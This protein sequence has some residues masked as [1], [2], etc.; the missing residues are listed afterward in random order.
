MV[1]PLKLSL[2]SIPPNVTGEVFTLTTGFC[3]SSFASFLAHEFRSSDTMQIEKKIEIFRIW[4]IVNCKLCIISV[5]P[6]II[7][8]YQQLFLHSLQ[9]YILS[10]S[11]NIFQQIFRAEERRVGKECRSR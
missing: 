7:G 6:I 1:L 10:F 11:R 8:V 3:S 4:I 5:V 2:L 9:Q